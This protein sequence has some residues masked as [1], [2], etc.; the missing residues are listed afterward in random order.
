MKARSLSPTEARVVLAAEAEGEE[1]LTVSDVRQKAHVSRGFAR[2]LSS[3]LV[4]KGWLQRTGRGR[5][6][7]SPSRNGPD[8]VPDADP[9]RFG[10]RLVD[11]YY[12][13]FA[14]AAELHGLLP[15]AGRV[16]YLVTPRRRKLAR[17]PAAEFRAVVVPPR[18]FFG[19][20]RLRRRAETVIVSDPERTV[21]DCLSRPELSGG[22]GGVVQILESAAGRLD[23]ARLDRYLRRWGQRSL[24]LRLGYL[25]ESQIPRAHPPTGWLGRL[26]ARPGEP[27]AP[28]GPPSE[29]GRRGPHDVRWHIVRNVPSP[30]LT[31]EVDIR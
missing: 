5:Y 13:G 24:E 8:A 19:F 9:L 10:S 3:G 22:L 27:Y 29:F 16:Y 12:F 11:P 2:K 14:T 30:L 15:Q 17:F 4:K 20:G 7:L 18:R 28:L 25:V 26:R 23:W 1:E 31:A 6:L 21:L